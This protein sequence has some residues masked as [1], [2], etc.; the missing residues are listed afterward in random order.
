AYEK[1]TGKE[2]WR[3]DRPKR[4]RSYCPPLIVEAGGKT[5]LVLSGSRSVTSYDPATGKL[6]WSIKGPT[7]QYVAGPVYGE[8]LFFL[9]TGFPGEDGST[10]VDEGPGPA[11]SRFGH[12]GR[13]T[14]VFHR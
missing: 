9:T 6:I 3:A 11:P 4:T 12:R 13:G 2:R 14:R 8:G 10:V 5:Q 7:E 1:T